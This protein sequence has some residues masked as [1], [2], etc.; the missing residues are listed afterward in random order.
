[1]VDLCLIQDKASYLCSNITFT[2]NKG[3]LFEL[4]L[5]TPGSV[6]IAVTQDHM[7]TFKT[8]L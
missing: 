6:V 2:P 1:M 3:N 5:R 7:R 4:N 8:D